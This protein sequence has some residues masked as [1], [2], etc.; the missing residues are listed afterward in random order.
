MKRFLITLVLLPVLSYGQQNLVPNGSFEEMDFCPVGGQW[1]ASDWIN[2]NGYTPDHFHSCAS[3]NSG[4]PVSNPYNFRGW[5]YPRSGEAYMGIMSFSKSHA[6][7]REYIQ[8]ELSEPL[9]ASVPYLVS[10]YLS[11]A[12]KGRYAISTLGAALT[13]APPP[14]IT[15]SNWPDGILDV[16]P[17][18]LHHPLVPLT[19]TTEW[20][21][22]RDTFISRLGGERYLSL[23]NFHTDGESDTLLCN[24]DAQL[25]STFSYYYIDDVSVIALDSVPSGVGE[26]DSDSN[27]FS[28]YPNPN[29]GRMTVNYDIGEGE[30]ATIVIYNMVGAL[31]FE[32]TLTS[33]GNLME[34]DVTN[35][36]SGVY[37]LNVEV[38]GEK[39]HTERLSI[40]KE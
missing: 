23:G 17:Q 35:I 18:I 6:E 25:G 24:T 22:V 27:E 34:I 37:L 10:F 20:I 3:T 13:V 39:R 21:L 38:N 28:V 15:L 33:S 11:S 12:E 31:M 26:A 16:V 36:N 14:A 19:D 32:R 5:Q 40:L 2:P 4:G 30:T 9:H 7:V 29:N 8:T 1:S